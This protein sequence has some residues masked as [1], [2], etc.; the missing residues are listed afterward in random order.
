MKV[1]LAGFAVA[2]VAGWG[3]LYF[4]TSGLLVASEG[5]LRQGNDGQDSLRCTYFHGTGMTTIF[6]WYSENSILGKAICPRIV[7]LQ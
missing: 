6:Y 2:L 4:T 5:P 1:A 3:L 7:S